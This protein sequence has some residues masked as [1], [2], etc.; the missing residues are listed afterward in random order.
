[1][2]ALTLILSQWARE[3]IRIGLIVPSSN[4]TMETEIP[5]LLR[6]REAI[7]PERFT[8]HSS[9]M[10][11]KRVSPEELAR[12][13]A[14]SDRCARELSDARCD[15]MAYACLVAIMAAGAGHHVSAESRL[16][17]TA[18]ENGG[19]ARVVTS[20]GALVD[21]IQAIGARRVA[22]IAPY[23]KALTQLV[24]EYLTASGIEVVDS[25]SLEVADNLAVGRLDPMQLP[26]IA[27]QLDL[28]NA[29]AL[30]LS[31][32]VQMPSLDAIDVAERRFGLPVFSAATATTRS[33]LNALGLEAH[34]P[35]AGA[36]LAAQTAAAI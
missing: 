10:S 8:F 1:M 3:P 11:M 35:G 14:E 18:V 23:V 2:S 26:D 29:D 20:A 6:R 22:V 33:L 17:R 32:C 21:G 36:L 31:A 19:P 9:R 13:D 4:T 30:V 28:S 25:V 12:M 16:T 24:I 5:A 15:A 27:A 7:A 34:I